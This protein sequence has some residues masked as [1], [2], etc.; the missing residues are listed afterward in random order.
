MRYLSSTSGFP[1]PIGKEVALRTQV[2][3]SGR[4]GELICTLLDRRSS[5]PLAAARIMCVGRDRRV[6]R[7]DTDEHGNFRAHLPQGVYD[8]VI[9][10]NGYLSLLVRGVGVLAD[11]QHVVTRGLVP[12]EGEFA[13]SEPATAIGGYVTDRIGRPVANVMMHANAEN[14]SFAYTTRT[15]RRGAYVLHGVVPELYDLTVRSM[16]RTLTRE[17]VPI[18]HVN[19][20]IRLDIRLNHM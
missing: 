14:G 1:K 3:E 9:S 15:D 13:E 12:G 11:Y 17:H 6:A 7:L 18:A 4:M 20:F 5:M 8:L 10:A 16:E 19:D 2:S